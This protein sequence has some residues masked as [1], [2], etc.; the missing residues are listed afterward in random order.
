MINLNLKFFYLLKILLIYFL[1]LSSSFATNDDIK[2]KLISVGP[3][4][5]A[6]K[7]KIFSSLT[8]PHCA[9]FHKN[10]VPKI[11]KNY[12]DP[13]KVQLIF[14]D[15][16]LDLAALNASKLL[17][18]LD[19]KKQMLFLDTIYENQSKWTIG[20]EI[21]EINSN[22]KKIVKNLG[23]SDNKFKKCLDNEDIEDKILNGRIDGE[24]KYSINS[25]PTII[26][27]EKKFKDNA[28]FE[29]IKKKIE[30]LI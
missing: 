27:N 21:S 24:K 14:I 19:K 23:I 26:I 10:V 9:N 3:D 1:I 17:H 29:N 28:N 8:C 2:K 15:F 30:N 11:K 4:N 5:A 13:G 7:I 22:L 18:C 16:P 25:T 6:V 20:S 12:V